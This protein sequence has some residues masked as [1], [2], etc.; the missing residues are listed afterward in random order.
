MMFVSIVVCSYNR[1]ELLMECLQSLM[2]MTPVERPWEILVIDNNSTDETKEAVLK[3]AA[4]NSRIKYVFEENQVLSIARNRAL[5][6][7]EAEWLFYFDDDGLAHKDLLQN[8]ISAKD[9][10]PSA[11]CIGG[12]YFAW[13]RNEKPKWWPE[14]WGEMTCPRSDAGPI[15]VASLS[16][17]IFAIKAD[18][19]AKIGLFNPLL[20]Q[21]GNVLRY[22]EEVQVQARLLEKGRQLIFDPDIRMDHLV[23]E[24]KLNILWHLKASYTHGHNFWLSQQI[25]RTSHYQNKIN[26]FK[27]IPRMLRQSWNNFKKLVTRKDYYFQNWI[28]DS[29]SEHIFEFGKFYS[30]D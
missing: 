9:S 20:G 30:K 25:E 10:F 8:F 1:K 27:L 18:A 28:F 26:L 11:E 16:G 12:R 22:G 7:S 6:E 14:G 5:K 29:F 17:G 24:Q 4:S 21:Q 19:L 23:A 3:L 15:N 13:F 2:E